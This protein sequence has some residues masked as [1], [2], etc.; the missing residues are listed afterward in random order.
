MNTFTRRN[1]LWLARTITLALL[2][3]TTSLPALA[4]AYKDYVVGVGR[5]VFW[6]NAYLAAQNQK[7]LFCMPEKLALDEGVILSLIDQQIRKPSTKD[8]SEIESQMVL[9]FMTIFPCQ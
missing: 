6:A 3:E 9:A 8:D 7:R 1:I 4:E 5:G 2:I